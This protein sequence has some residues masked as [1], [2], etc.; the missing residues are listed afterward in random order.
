MT[1]IVDLSCVSIDVGTTSSRESANL[2]SKAYWAWAQQ[3][4][5]R[6]AAAFE[7]CAQYV[8]TLPG[9]IPH[10]RFWSELVET[11]NLGE[12]GRPVRGCPP[13]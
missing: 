2:R 8:C 3:L 4:A 9:T 6:F 7:A 10:T 5:S 12:T 11:G 13:D 1:F